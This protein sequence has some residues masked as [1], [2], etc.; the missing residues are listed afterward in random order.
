[1]RSSPRASRTEKSWADHDLFPAS[2]DFPQKGDG[3]DTR[4]AAAHGLSSRYAR[5]PQ[6]RRPGHRIPPQGP[7]PAHCGP[8]PGRLRLGWSISSAPHGCGVALRGPGPRERSQS[9]PGPAISLHED[10]SHHRRY[11]DA[12]WRQPGGGRGSAD[13]RAR[14]LP[15]E[16]EGADPVSALRVLPADRGR[17]SGK[18]P[19]RAGIQRQASFL[20]MGMGP[21]RWW[22][23]PGSWTLP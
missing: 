1:M 19:R 5:T 12:G 18:R 6:D 17:L 10:L 3:R 4:G 14:K 8:F 21:R 16:R 7:R 13:R 11:F 15:P 23:R 9:R 20:E 2:N 22:K